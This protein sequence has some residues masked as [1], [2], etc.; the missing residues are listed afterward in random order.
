MSTRV[1]FQKTKTSISDSRKKKT[2]SDSIAIYSK[3]YNSKGVF[4]PTFLRKGPIKSAQDLADKLEYDSRLVK[5]RLRH[6][7][8]CIPKRLDKQWTTTKQGHCF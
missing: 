2:P 4:H 6:F 8:L 7:Y 3:H 5:T 1:I